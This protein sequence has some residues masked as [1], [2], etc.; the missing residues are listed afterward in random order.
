MTRHGRAAPAPD[1]RGAD[2]PVQPGRERVHELD[3]ERL[4]RP[5]Q[6]P[7]IRRVEGPAYH[8]RELLDRQHRDVHVLGPTSSVRA[9]T[10]RGSTRDQ[11]SSHVRMGSI[12]A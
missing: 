8:G 5:L 6:R 7:R 1:L 3:I 2:D 12:F 9:A 10:S 4:A 11:V